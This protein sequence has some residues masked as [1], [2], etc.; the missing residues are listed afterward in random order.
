MS[1]QAR[2]QAARDAKGKFQPLTLEP[3][4]ESD[5][6]KPTPEPTPEPPKPALK[7]LEL[8][9]ASQSLLEE[10]PIVPDAGKPT[11]IAPKPSEIPAAAHVPKSQNLLVLLGGVC[12]A[13]LLLI[14]GFGL[15]RQ[16]QPKYVNP[17]PNDQAPVPVAAPPAPRNTTRITEV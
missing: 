8:D 6:P 11:I 9:A 14:A 4:P 2:L 5:S 1:P 7:K 3:T 10:N 16:K 13:G 17:M 12:A 15:S